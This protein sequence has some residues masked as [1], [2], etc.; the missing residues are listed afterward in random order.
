MGGDKRQ[1]ERPFTY[2]PPKA[3][4]QEFETMLRES[5][6]S[7]NAF[8]N[9]AVFGRTRHRPAE[10]KKLAQLLIICAAIADELREIKMNGADHSILVLEHIAEELRLVRTAIMER[11]GRRS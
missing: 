2:R 5:G 10:N 8:L 3:R 11:L 7:V 1:R 4:R 6:L 9:E